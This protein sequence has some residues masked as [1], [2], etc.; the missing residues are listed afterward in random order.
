MHL[1]L[2]KSIVDELH[3]M[4]DSS[5][6]N[7]KY[8]FEVRFGIFENKYFIPSL[9]YNIFKNILEDL[10]SNNNFENSDVFDILSISNN[11]IDNNKLYKCAKD[12]N[13]IKKICANERYIDS[14]VYFITKT[15]KLN[16]CNVENY[17]IRFEL[18]EEN[19]VKPTEK[20]KEDLYNCSEKCYRYKKRYSFVR[21]NGLFRIDLSITKTSPNYDDYKKGIIGFNS[22]SASNVL[23]KNVNYECE[24]EYLPNSDLSIFK[25]I[26]ENNI[27]AQKELIFNEFINNIYYIL[28]HIQECEYP[29]PKD[30]QENIF[31]NY[32]N[33]FYLGNKK[34]S[35]NK[36]TNSND[37]NSN[38]TNSNNTNSADTNSNEIDYFDLPKTK[39]NFFLGADTCILKS[40]NLIDYNNNINKYINSESPDDYAITLKAD[41][42]RSLL[43]IDESGYVYIMNNRIKFK[44]TGIKI[45]NTLKNTLID[46]EF[47]IDS[48]KFLA[49][50]LI[51]FNGTDY[52]T[53]ILNR[54]KEEK[55]SN[56]YEISRLEQLKKIIET[57]NYHKKNFSQNKKSTFSLLLKHYEFP[58]LV[59]KN[60]FEVASNMWNNKNNNDFNVDG[61]IFTPR[62]EEYHNVAKGFRWR[63]QL[64]WK[65]LEMTSIDF[66]V[67]VSQ[68][69]NIDVVKPFRIFDKATNNYIIK[70]YKTIYL[71]VGQKSG[72]KYLPTLFKPYEGSEL[73]K[74][75]CFIAKI[76]C[77]TDGKIYAYDP[78][79]NIKEEIQNNSIVEFTYD[80]NNSVGFEWV[81]IRIRHDKTELF[82][83]TRSI[84]NTANDINIATSTWK[85]IHEI[86][87][88]LLDNNIFEL[89][90]DKFYYNK[91]LN[92][93]S[94]KEQGYYNVENNLFE[95]LTEEEKMIKRKDMAGNLRLFN[96]IIK[97][98][99]YENVSNL[100]KNNTG[101][102]D[103][104]LL[105]L[106]AGRGGDLLKYIKSD[107][108]KVTAIDLD[109]VNITQMNKRYMEMDEL[110]K[111]NL[112]LEI[113]QGDFSKLLNNGDSSK[114]I[115]TK[116]RDDLINK[117]EQEGFYNY[118][119]ISS[120]FSIHYAFKDEISVRGFIHNIFNNLRI[121]GYFFG[122]TFN[123]KVI[124]DELKNNNKIT[125]SYTNDEN[126]NDILYKI[127]KKYD[128]K[129][130][131]KYGQKIDFT[132]KN[133]SSEPISEYLVNFDYLVNVL[134]E[135]Y[136]IVLL[137]N[138]ELSSLG[139]NKSIDSFE[140]LYNKSI[141]ENKSFKL[142]DVEKELVFKYYY[143]VFKKVG[144][145][146]AKEIQ[147]WNKLITL[148]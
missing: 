27:K 96:N 24:I 82:K 73:R 103:L 145:G 130:F 9:K 123:G 90:N 58:K 69:N 142:Q 77:D 141:N 5:F 122:T 136:D 86:D 18:S 10:Y 146:N 53:R 138:N 117:Y 107:I 43:Y 59:N 29:I 131:L 98:Y 34:Y 108:K 62:K 60:M 127:E 125:G 38:N 17:D 133:I 99:L 21:N 25:D 66:L 57:F 106:G 47:L 70:D 35:K 48:N 22:F 119:L 11:T 3:K 52:R 28:K 139:L 2:E 144:T 105:D 75:D 49:F 74:T 30:F 147:K 39:K 32:I 111:K 16:I 46:G 95:G 113:Y 116:S 12:I 6:N 50:D 78:S 148:K 51:Y 112:K 94:D 84:S 44:D 68:T 80:K 88:L 13:S 8:E 140:Y 124:F 41:G 135:D 23:D 100:Y 63:N 14:N 31:H 93:V 137:D 54:T 87:G 126:N 7:S 19:D 118:N 128:N 83:N 89:I 1:N 120:Q 102:N 45:V 37:I 101:I 143:F 79:T 97:Y 104:K 132:F 4:I 67:S 61:L 91:I 81:P 129:D 36:K 71:K 64:K 56:L 134:K 121:G 55:D 26:P 42:E 33:S 72:K 76:F 114:N 115:N 65:P 85:L 109:K 15:K 40:E 20:E 92:F 110:N